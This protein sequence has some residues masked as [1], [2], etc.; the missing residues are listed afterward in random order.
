[1]IPLSDVSV[2][3]G[4]LSEL[5]CRVS[6]NPLPVV[7]WFKNDLCIDAVPN[8]EITYNNGDAK[9]LIKNTA[10]DDTATYTC[11]AVNPLGTLSTSAALKVK[12]ILK[13]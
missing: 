5:Y 2:L 4:D 7:Q 3:D 12:G 9:L 11:I 13:V 8:Y 1:M 10:L 6:G